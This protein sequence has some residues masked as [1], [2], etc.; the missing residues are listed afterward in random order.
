M[1]TP[2]ILLAE[3]DILVA[4][5]LR[6]H[7]EEMGYPVSAVVRS[8]DDAPEAARTSGAELAI[9]DIRMPGRMDGIDAGRQIQERLEIPII[10]LTAHADDHTIERARATSP[11]AYLVKPCDPRELQ[12]AIEIATARY[13][14]ER[15][16]RSAM[17]RLALED[18]VTGLAN[19]R[20]FH[21]R[22]D[23]ALAHL[24]RSRVGFAVVFIDLDRFKTVNDNFGHLVGDEV[25]AAVAGRIRGSFREEDTVARIG[26]DEFG[27]ILTEVGNPGAAEDAVRRVLREL[28][29]PIDTSGGEIRLGASIGI[30]I[31]DRLDLDADEI[32]RRSDFAMYRTKRDGGGSYSSFD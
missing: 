18:P 26:G 30:T 16:K 29:N 2:R 15:E 27:A 13:Q 19:R 9:L 10:Y 31:V 1:L 23:R 22:L 12:I 5:D 4:T 7:L 11:M 21:D 3:D 20:L 6:E 25:L 14:A 32:L 28:A 17:E 8:G 24:K